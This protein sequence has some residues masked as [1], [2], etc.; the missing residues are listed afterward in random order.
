MTPIYIDA[1]T[2]VAKVPEDRVAL[3]NSLAGE[4]IG[5]VLHNLRDTLIGLYCDSDN[6]FV[7]KICDDGSG[8][9]RVETLHE[10]TLAQVVFDIEDNFE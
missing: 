8:V 7:I 5:S 10:E 9:I 2:I 6:A 1:E 4:A 3:L